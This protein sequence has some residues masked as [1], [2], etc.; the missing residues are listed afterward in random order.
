MNRSRYSREELARLA[1]DRRSVHSV[2]IQGRVTTG[3]RNTHR[4]EASFPR[5][6]VVLSHL[7]IGWNTCAICG[8]QYRSWMTDTVT[9]RRLPK[10]MWH[11]TLCTR[12]FRRVL[13]ERAR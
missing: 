5:R 12:C 8:R 2:V 3:T 4:F 9:W 7:F 13:T 11:L 1:T 6:I 10:R